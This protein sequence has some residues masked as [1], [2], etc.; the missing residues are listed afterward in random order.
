MAP[1]CSSS[2][3]GRVDAVQLP[4]VD[5]IESQAAQASFE[6]FAQPR[7]LAVRIPS[8]G[9]GPVQA[10]L[11]GDDEILRI[12]MQ[13]LRDQLLA[14]VRT[15]RLRG[16]DQVHAELDGATKDGETFL[17]VLRRPP[18]TV[19]RETHRAESEAMDGKFS[20]DGKRAAG[21]GV[22]R[23]GVVDMVASQCI[24]NAAGL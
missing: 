6:L 17:P 14:D 10:A 20:A 7:R 18:D 22:E 19:A 5:P 11:G 13:R 3:H 1:N 9:T 2:G 21:C 15:I 4:E 8:V 12:R 16:I 23:V 24:K